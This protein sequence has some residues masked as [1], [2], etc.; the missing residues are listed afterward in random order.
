MKLGIGSRN[1]KHT[2]R[3][4]AYEHCVFILKAQDESQARVPIGTRV[5]GLDSR[6]S[7]LYETIHSLL[8]NSITWKLNSIYIYCN[9]IIKKYKFY[10]SQDLGGK[11]GRPLHSSGTPRWDNNKKSSRY[12]STIYVF[13]FETVR[14]H[15]QYGDKVRTS[16]LR[17]YSHIGTDAVIH[18]V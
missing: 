1:T 12:I 4:S 7:F 13:T 15:I 6:I 17:V 3:E 16:I 5:L 10:P 2:K 9:K 11:E 8:F 18:F 14:S